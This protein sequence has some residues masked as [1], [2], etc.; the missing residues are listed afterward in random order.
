[1]MTNAT[2]ENIQKFS[3]L[4]ELP[5]LVS[6]DYKIQILVKYNSNIC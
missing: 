6:P 3:V 2:V 1:M 5:F 4:A